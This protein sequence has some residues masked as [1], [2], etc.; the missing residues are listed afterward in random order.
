MI[1]SVIFII[2]ILLQSISHACSMND[3]MAAEDLSAKTWDELEAHFIK[4]G[5]CDDGS[6]S[7]G[8]SDVVSQLFLLE[9]EDISKIIVGSNFHTFILKH[10]DLTW[11]LNRYKQI[12]ALAINNCPHGSEV[13]CKAIINVTEI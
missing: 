7:E 3:S 10:I 9:W 8:Y 4:Y 6:V 1:R 5:H 13:I 2:L 11:E 12:R